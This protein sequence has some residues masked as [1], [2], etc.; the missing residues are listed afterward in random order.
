MNALPA[1]PLRHTRA[2]RLALRQYQ[3]HRAAP[4]AQAIPSSA[5]A[6]GTLQ[7]LMGLAVHQARTASSDYNHRL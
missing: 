5:L 1:A 2:N 6:L 3:R 7:V 4:R